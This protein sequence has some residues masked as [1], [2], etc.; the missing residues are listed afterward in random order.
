MAQQTVTGPWIVTAVTGIHAA[1]SS[2]GDALAAECGVRDRP[3]RLRHRTARG[4][5]RRLLLDERSA[6]EAAVEAGFHDQA[7]LT[8]HFKR[9]LGTTPGV[10]AG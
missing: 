5:G 8:R 1:L 4:P 2:P 7:H 10:F 9:V 3:V 6:S